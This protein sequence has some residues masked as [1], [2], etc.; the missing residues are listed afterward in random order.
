MHG[1]RYYGDFLGEEFDFFDIWRQPLGPNQ[2]GPDKGKVTAFYNGRLYKS[3][4][5]NI[6]LG[7]HVQVQ[8]DVGTPLVAPE[9][10]SFSGTG[11]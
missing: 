2:V 1:I 3:N 8:L 11:L 6:P 9:K 7:S 4:P 5:R 10:V